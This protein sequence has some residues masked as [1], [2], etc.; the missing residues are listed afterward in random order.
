MLSGSVVCECVCMLDPVE[1]DLHSV[2]ASEQHSKRR[3][4][5]EL[6]KNL[7]KVFISSSISES[8]PGTSTIGSTIAVGSQSKQHGVSS[9]VGM[10]HTQV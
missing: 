9:N 3:C 4:W 2:A 1:F 5:I 8:L 10:T 7:A 6:S